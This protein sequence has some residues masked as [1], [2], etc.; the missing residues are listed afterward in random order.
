[1]FSV[2]LITEGT[3]LEVRFHGCSSEKGW[4][5][6]FPLPFLIIDVP[7]D[8]WPHSV[9]QLWW[10]AVCSSSPCRSLPPC[11]ENISYPPSSPERCLPLSLGIFSRKTLATSLYMYTVISSPRQC[12]REALYVNAYCRSSAPCVAS[13]WNGPC[14]S[15]D[16]KI[17]HVFLES[18]VLTAA[19]ERCWD[20]CVVHYDVF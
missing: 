2:S 14:F 19:I 8:N 6:F 13:R 7:T 5:T 3:P 20:S 10:L 18:F 16:V 12:P 15:F 17:K 1:M 4:G 11:R 9:R